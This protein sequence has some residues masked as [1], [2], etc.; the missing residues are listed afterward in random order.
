M[1]A[2]V[3]AVVSPVGGV[4]EVVVDGLSGLFAAPGDVATLQRLLRKVLLDR[5][6]GER[7][8][9]AASESVRLRCAPERALAQLAALYAQLGVPAFVARPAPDVA[10]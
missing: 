10:L 3:P 7:I 9:A 8:G 2:G 4:P 1:A 5:K 6:F